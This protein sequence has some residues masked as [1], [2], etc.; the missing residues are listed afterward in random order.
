MKIKSTL[1]VSGL[2]LLFGFAKAQ[3]ILNPTQV[4]NWNPN[5]LGTPSANCMA[6]H[7]PTANS[8]NPKGGGNEQVQNGNGTIATIYTMTAC[9]LNYVLGEVK[10]GKRYFPAAANQP[11]SMAIAGIPVCKQILRAYLYVGG[12]GN[13]MAFS[14]TMTNPAATTSVFPM[15]MIGT[16]ID[17]CWGYAG[18]YN[19]RADVTALITGN[20][21][22]VISGVPTSISTPGNDMDGASLVIIYADPTQN[23]TGHIVIGDGCQVNNST[24]GVVTNTL[25]GFSSCA[26]STFANAFYII[27]DL[28]NINATTLN[29]NS[30]ANIFTYPAASNKWWDNIQGAANPVTAGQNQFFFGATNTGDCYNIV[31]E[32]VYW[33]TNCNV[34]TAGGMTVNTVVSSSCTV[35][36]ATAIVTGGNAPYSYTWTPTA[37]NTSVIT[38]VAA[39]NYTVTVKDASGCLTATA[40]AVIPISSTTLSVNSATICAGKSATLTAVGGNT[41]TWT[42]AATLNSANGNPVIATPVATTI[43]TV[44]GTNTAGCT[45]T[46]VATV[47][48]NP[49]PI[50]AVNN[51]TTCVGT[52]FTLIPTPGFTAYAWTGPNSYNSPIQNPTFANAQVSHSGNY[53]VLVTSAVG[54][55]NSAVGNVSVVPLPTITIA[56]T[57]T[58]CSQN[59]NGSPNTVVLTASGGN[60]YQWTLP[61]GF[62]ASPNLS[63]NPITLTPPVTAVPLVATMTVVGTSGSCSNQAVYTITVIPNPTIAVT[64]GSM[65]A[66]TSVTLTASNA[67]TYT[68]SPATALNTTNGPV[69]IANPAVTT[70]YSIIGS[71]LGCNSQTQ[72]AT[73]SVVPNPTVTINPNPALICL[74]SSI[75]LTA[76]GA[77]NYTW[78]P[79][80]ALTTTNTANTTANPTVTTTYS[81]IG[82]QATCTNL[83]TIQVSVIGLPTVSI[84]GTN[85]LCSQNFNGSP[86]TTTLTASG[87]STYQ[88]TLPVGFSATPNLSSNPIVVTPPATSVPMVV[89]MTV[90]GT[91]GSCTNQ[92]VYT[93]TVIPNPTIAVTSGSMCAGTSVNLTAS[94]AT[95]Y[96]WTPST[97]LNTPNG[98]NVIANPSVTTVYSVIGSSVG[99]NS[100]T[101]N[102]TASVVPNPTVTINPN[103]AL[104][105]LG[106]SINLTAS[107]ATNYTWSPNIALTTT[108]GPNTTASPTITTTYS[109]LGSQATCTNLATV[110]VSVIGLPTVSIA[111]TNTLCSQNFNG[112]PNT[113]TLTASGAGTYVWTLP[114]GFSGSP[115]LTSNP[116][117]ITPPATSVP[118]VA[119]MTVLGTAGTCTSLAVFNLTVVPNPTIATTSGSM[120]AG[121]SVNLTASNATTYTWTPSATLNTANGP[122][123]IAS[124]AV[125]TIYII[126]GGSS[127]CNSQTQNATANVVA[128]PTVTILPNPAVIC[129]NQA[130]NLTASGANNY[131]WSPNV[132]L[133]TT[134]GP[135][136]TANPTV[137]TVYQVIG[138]AATCTHVANITVSVLPLP[139][140]TIVPSSPTLC[141]NNFNGSPNTVSLTASGAASYTWG[142]IIGL[143]TNTLN[144]STIIGTANGNNVPSGTVIGANGTCTSI[145]T[146]TLSV[147]DNPIITVTSASMCAGTSASLTASN[148]ITYT[149]SPSATLNTANGPNV[150]ASPA[151]TTVYSV[152]GGSVGCNSQ[153]Q[154]GVVTVVN[155]PTVSIAPAT[156][157]ICFGGSINL[158][159]NGANNY[160]WSPNT[161][162]TST[163]GNAAT[164]NPTVTTV[165]SIIG[166]AAT[167]TN[168][169]AQTVTVIPLPIINIG[170]S[171]GSMCMNNFNGSNNQITVTAS[172]ATSYNW[173]GFTGIGNS[174]NSGPNVIVTA[175]PN[176][177][178]GT[179]TVIGTVG[180]CT[181]IASFTVIAIPNPV[182]AVTSASMCLGTSATLNAS[183]ATTY[184]WSP[185][186]TLNQTTG[187]SV[188]A[189]PSNSTVYSVVGTSLNCNSTTQTGTVDVVA[190]PVIVIA[191]VTPTICAG[192][193]IG[194]SAFGANNYTWAPSNS[195][196]TAF[197]ANVIASPT[198]TTNYIV[199]GEAATCT[200]TAMRQVQVIQ[201]PTL[202]AICDN[203]VICLGDKTNINA[204]GA[205]SYT[206]NPPHGLSSGSSN[207]VVANPTSSM[208]YTLI[209]TNGV[210]TASLSVPIIVLQKPVL[211]LTTSAPRICFGN[212]STIF[213]SGA[214]T[215][216][217]EPMADT[218]VANYAIVSPSV[219][220]NYTVTGV[221][222]T[223]T[224][225]CAFTKE[226]QVE[227]VPQ[228][229]ASVSNSVVICEGQ[230]VRLS[231]G[232][233][234]TY[235]WA[236]GVGLNNQTVAQPYASP[237]ITTEYTV[238]VSNGVYCSSKATVLVKVNPMPVVDAGP[239]LKFNSDEPMYLDAK[240]TGTLTWVMGDGIL[241]HVCPNSQ[242]MTK[243][244]GVYQ[245]R[246]VNE[247]GCTAEDFVNIEVTN[248][249]SIYIPNVFTPNFDDK[250]DTFLVYGVGI[251]DI[252]VTIFD[253]WG[254]QIYHDENQTKGWDGVYKDE[255]AKNDVYIYLVKYTALDGKKHTK[256]GHVTLLK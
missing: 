225:G 22:Y 34:C 38:N 125:T 16:H 103:P 168:T 6:A 8:T 120:C 70:V 64:S 91:A 45:G 3:I 65:C 112:S 160:T 236:P 54:C 88:W 118:M 156:P 116:I 181:N 253:R 94:N 115:N 15:T 44:T 89:T 51:P 28:Q 216:S 82:S 58:L 153:T 129:L 224:V 29:M 233:S 189:N 79:S 161:A 90:L 212:K 222:F 254:E 105:C 53:T 190:N 96:T 78:T 201:L 195:L 230:S 200:S 152:I 191:P 135:N 66:G 234:N 239:D 188:I 170:L 211:N 32:G 127:G 215:Y 40:L 33:R 235:L 77:T 154:N 121:T 171:N 194:L 223:G 113:T 177:P 27:S 252:S 95:T 20:G 128:N 256:T 36:S 208:N 192:G 46:A 241:C 26:A 4:A 159:A 131:T 169:A 198:I 218:T 109:I 245:I 196:N 104:I 147:I 148:A 228:V 174:T 145:A 206:W 250:N 92:A 17:K 24:F 123:V 138:E 255:I 111:G 107:G 175:I 150:I 43:Y 87:A 204:N 108:L 99:C 220:T 144:G 69:V 100:Q 163:V 231:A 122:S 167:C 217:W 130:I 12:S 80:T 183:G 219:T 61:G 60:T 202:Q 102:G 21:N 37:L 137:T 143:S 5:M 83:A 172:G 209:G 187:S 117:V 56:G 207:F 184:V 244:S 242:F 243:Q 19:Y 164:V 2:L 81:I 63:S 162:I 11:V 14:T 62:S 68:W 93:I 179:G 185:G 35:G 221:N 9:G 126:V 139:T 67:S 134:N 140:I 48:V 1:F 136:T 124:P 214:Q 132:A 151:V 25:T 193:S 114:A 106:S 247:F 248:E 50:V 182:I 110:Q 197:G 227:V 97:S 141:M 13:G 52:T 75:N 101:Q 119:T 149:W 165:Y 176:S 251:S 157:T 210:C 71:S 158:T 73:A 7:V 39:G 42:P 155:N 246:A 180:T 57:N 76:T 10:T 237:N 213:A 166:E 49:I 238:Y 84:A 173:I 18:T 86:N 146:F 31:T 142:P 55:T 203:S 226:I 74:G 59:F 23:Y 72:N 85:T 30:A 249:Y 178:I 186:N 47:V 240:G 229:T 199:I 98:P 232:G 133:T 205:N 41:Y